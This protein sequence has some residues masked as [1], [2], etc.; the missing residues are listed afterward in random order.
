[1]TEEKAWGIRFENVSVRYPNGTLALD[2]VS[3]DI[4]PGEFVAIVGLSG[5]GKSTFIRSING[6]VQPT[7]GKI[8]VGPHEISAAKGSQLRK[9]LSLIHI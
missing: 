3:V 7:S 5:S 4:A 2:D 8:F 9:L 1:M 6:L